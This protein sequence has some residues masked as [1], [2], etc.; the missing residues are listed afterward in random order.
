M[1]MAATAATA[2]AWPSTSSSVLAPRT[3]HHVTPSPRALRS[4]FLGRALTLAAAT[5]RPSSVSI[6]V[7]AAWDGPLSSARLIM[8][9]RNVKLTE[10]LKEH[11]EDKVGRAVHN[12][13][14]LVRE[15][16][17]RLSARG[18][19]LSKGP[20]LSRC[21]VTLFTR[22][23]GVVRA[24]EEEESSYASIDAAAAVV[25][26]KLR[27]IKEKETDVRHLKGTKEWQ[28]S[29]LSDVEDESEA[30]EEEE[31][32]ELVEVIGAEDE[33]SVLTKVVRTKV[34]EMAP[35]TVDEALEQLENVD[36]DFYAFRNEQTGEVNIL[37]K[38][39]EGGFGLIIPKQ[40]GHVDKATVNAKEKE[41]PVAG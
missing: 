37:Y 11:I 39:N 26:R 21:E 18:G 31:D 23:H 13:A 24:E 28:S 25:K 3:R 33:E 40:D 34:F 10:K 22:R 6:S 17:V 20:K 2:T 12:H 14:H 41:H 5:D 7:R 8:Q 30:E 27:K 35:L 32:D 4:G 36:H 19:D 9:G 15:V 38:R 16:D 29:G 1:S